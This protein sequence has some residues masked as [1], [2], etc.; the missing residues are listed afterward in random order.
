LLVAA[1]AILGAFEIAHQASTPLGAA[2]EALPLLQLV[3]VSS[4]VVDVS[5]GDASIEFT[6]AASDDYSGIS[7]VGISAG[8]SSATVPGQGVNLSWNRYHLPAGSQTLELVSGTVNDG[9]WRGTGIV[10]GFSGACEIDG[11]LIDLCDV[12]GCVSYLT[13]PMSEAAGD[14]FCDPDDYP[15]CQLRPLPFAPPAIQI[16]DTG[17]IDTVP[18]NILALS[19][20]KPGLAESRFMESDEGVRPGVQIPGSASIVWPDGTSE[21]LTVEGVSTGTRIFGAGIDLVIEGLRRDRTGALVVPEGRSLIA[22]LDAGV[23]DAEVIEVW[24]YS[25]PRIVAA[26]RSDGSGATRLEIPLPVPLDGGPPIVSGPHTL[27]MRIPGSSGMFIVNVAIE[28]GVPI[29][30]GIQAG[31]TGVPESHAR[32]TVIAAS[33]AAIFALGRWKSTFFERE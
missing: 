33:V 27:Q 22:G 4:T 30:S 11:W 19:V 24:V 9:V 23:A 32:P 7:A 31:R 17:P 28:I 10:R 29:P 8:C 13:D 16:V 1:T 6:L 5:A 26:A 21:D 12:S 20:S 14:G 15:V 18:P 3:S 2:Q 25:A